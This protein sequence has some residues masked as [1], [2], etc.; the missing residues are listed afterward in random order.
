MSV[1]KDYPK[2][3]PLNYW[4]M[5]S[6]MFILFLL[7]GWGCQKTL[8]SFWSSYHVLTST[9][10]FLI[11]SRWEKLNH[12][13]VLKTSGKWE[14][15]KHCFQKCW[16]AKISLNT[17]ISKYYQELLFKLMHTMF[18]A[19]GERKFEKQMLQNTTNVLMLI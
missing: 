1:R 18:L 19:L 11:I 12:N 14:V 6:T 13:K 7:I 4:W 17:N 10:S 3:W 8:N 5:N 16:L 9:T 2:T 15:N